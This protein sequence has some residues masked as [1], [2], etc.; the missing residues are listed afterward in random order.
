VPLDATW[1]A[2]IMDPEGR[3]VAG[4]GVLV[5]ARRI[6][7]CAHVIG[8][9]LGIDAETRALDGMVKVDFPQ[10]PQV[11]SLDARVISDGWFPERAAAGDLAMIEVLGP[12]PLPVAPAPLRLAGEPG[13]RM[14]SVLG[15]PAGQDNG[16]WASAMLIAWGGPRREWIQLDALRSVGKRIQKGYSGA[17]V[18][19]EE[20]EAVIGCVVAE[21]RA[22]QD[23][24]AWMIPV[25]V[26]CQYWPDLR[27]ILQRA[28]TAGRQPER[29]RDLVLMPAADRE[30]MAALLFGLRG[31]S[32]PASR[33]LFIQAI[34]GQFAGRLRVDRQDNGLLDTLA[35]VDACLEHPGALHELIA[36]LRL[37]HTAESDRRLVTEI[38]D[39]GEAVDPAPLLDPAARNSLYR[40]LA[41]LAQTTNVQMVLTA[42][43]EAAGPLS[44]QD[45]DPFDL[46]SVVR[47]LESA[48]SGPDGL[49]PLLGFLEGL[50]RRLPEAETGGLRA[51]VDDFAAREGIPRHLI[52]RL[53]ISSPP[54][55]APATGYLLAELSPDGPDEQRFL[56]RIT[57]LRGD[58]R[59]QPRGRVL[60]LGREALTISQLQRL[61]DSVL[62]GLW[63]A[64]TVDFDDLVIEFLLPFGL[65][66]QAV[67]QW[68]V[69]AEVMAHPVCVEHRVV[70]R[71]RDRVTLRRSHLQWREKT[72]Q[73]RNGHATIRWAD[74]HDRSDLGDRLIRDLVGDGAACLAF[75]RPPVLASSLGDDAVSI[76]IRTGVPVIVWCRDEASA[77]SF[78]ARLR[79]YLDQEGVADLPSLVRQMRTESVR[80][81]DRGGAHITL[82]WDL[83]DE[84]TAPVIQHQA[85]MR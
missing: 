57:L 66:G 36:R 29:R 62:T 1:H 18:W 71:C 73:L 75:V 67:D 85:P 17:G 33:A 43:Q 8:R 47:I 35:L 13:R 32:D 22:E 25:E 39:I 6:V 23:R 14:I 68:E 11:P 69:Q 52:S 48:T 76:A 19:D 54:S 77:G 31:I 64:P 46:P 2:R 56:S 27:A 40:I 78:V 80:S 65:L 16:V 5:T 79:A 70:V 7:T 53:R 81:P 61:F 21:D 41:M 42:Y 37:F 72:R 58:R 63:E 12:E 10:C 9:A 49:P 3:A 83:E 44:T 51:W 24:V 55:S 50:S 84:P 59:R 82:V 34:E 4:A 60:H 30:R 28:P 26:I 15:H 38:S 45:I 74:P 20:N